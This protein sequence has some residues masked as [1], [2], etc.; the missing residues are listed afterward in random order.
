[1]DLTGKVLQNT[2]SGPTT[3]SWV[4]TVRGQAPS[5]WST[6]TQT[7]SSEYASVWP[8]GLAGYE[9]PV[10]FPHAGMADGVVVFFSASNIIFK[11]DGTTYTLNYPSGFPT[12]CKADASTNYNTNLFITDGI[13]SVTIARRPSNTANSNICVMPDCLTCLEVLD[14]DWSA[15]SYDDSMITRRG[16]TTPTGPTFW[17]NTEED[18]MGGDLL[19]TVN[20]KPS[21]MVATDTHPTWELGTSLANPFLST[22]SDAYTC[23]CTLSQL[24]SCGCYGKSGYAQ[25][26]LD[27]F[28]HV[29]SSGYLWLGDRGHDNGGF[30]NCHDTTY[31]PSNAQSGYNDNII[32][33][34]KTN[35]MLTELA[36][37]VEL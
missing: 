4:T 7:L 18:F 13:S 19:W 26:G 35:V 25:W 10:P 8:S 21:Y 31:G 14:F 34:A 36:D 24:A 27:L 6:S 28:F 12:D 20:G 5:S 9:R 16:A 23:P 2:A 11:A 37:G 3:G 1:V 32:G 15:S 29:D 17:Q 30:F 22:A 33:V